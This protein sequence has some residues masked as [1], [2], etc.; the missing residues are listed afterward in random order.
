MQVGTRNYTAVDYLLK[1]HRLE[2]DEIN[3]ILSQALSVQKQKVKF[4]S[5]KKRNFQNKPKRQLKKHQKS[6]F[7]PM[8]QRVEK[9]KTINLTE[10]AAGWLYSNRS[11]NTENWNAMEKDGDKILIHEKW[12]DNFNPQNDQDK[13]TIE[14]FLLNRGVAKRYFECYC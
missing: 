6:K 13:G 7:Q 10:F 3:A 5:T 1:H 8:K 11:K 2:F 9:A 12:G 4:K 14:N